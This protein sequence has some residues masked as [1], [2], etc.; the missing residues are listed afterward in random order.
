MIIYVKIQHLKTT[1]L[2]QNLNLYLKKKL[3]QERLRAK[4]ATSKHCKG[5]QTINN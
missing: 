3:K 1:Q 2:F 5:L 4:D